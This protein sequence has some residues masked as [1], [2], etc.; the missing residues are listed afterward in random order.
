MP[1]RL[2]D[3]DQSHR[4][5]IRVGV[6][7]AGLALVCF[8]SLGA[9]TIGG[10]PYDYG[11]GGAGCAP[12]MW[13]QTSSVAATDGVITSWELGY[14][15]AF[16]KLKV[17][18]PSAGNSFDVIAESARGDSSV[19]H[20]VR[21]AVRQGDQ[22]GVSTQTEDAII[23]PRTGSAGRTSGYLASDPAPGAHAFYTPGTLEIPLVASVEPDADHD[24][25]GDETQDGCPTNGA[26]T[27][28][29]PLPTV[30]GRTF[31]PS[32]SPC[33]DTRLPISTLGVVVRAPS[34][35][36]ITSWSHQTG[37]AASGTMRLKAFRPLG[38]DVY[39]AVGEDAPHT[40]AASTLNTFPVRIP[41]AAGD[42]MGLHATGLP[43]LS[44]VTDSRVRTAGVPEDPPVGT[45]VNAPVGNARDLDLSA[46]LEPDADA[47]GYGDVSQDGCP[48]QAGTAGACR[49][50]A[51]PDTAFKK[52]PKKTVRTGASKGTIKLT[53][54]SSEPGST[55]QCRLDKGD[56]TT[57]NAAL[58]LKLKVGKHALSV[59]AVDAAGN[60]D[61]TPVVAKI[62]VKRTP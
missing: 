35:G 49:D 19:P 25:Y 6:A 4:R 32:S 37:G 23:C 7:A 28:P 48:S 58:K 29:C 8:S 40:M 20:P 34:A 52:A 56:Y 44:N 47:D 41:V 11:S 62:K 24:G 21:I 18:R 33:T 16:A 36:V 15:F 45:A 22:V 38:N 46:V 30:L 10:S 53:L 55:F 42:L 50:L 51:A 12:G 26:T 39:L 14:A 60:V 3:L 57:C 13:V 43:C 61:A 9:Q 2:P 31:V 1:R 5:A 59:R 54:V 27:G 17:V